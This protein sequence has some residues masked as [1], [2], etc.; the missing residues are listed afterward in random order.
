MTRSGGG[1]Q[2]ED[3]TIEARGPR[4]GQAGHGEGWL[5]RGIPRNEGRDMPESES[6]EPESSKNSAV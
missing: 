2:V 4:K 3:R 1:R 5:G 6:Q